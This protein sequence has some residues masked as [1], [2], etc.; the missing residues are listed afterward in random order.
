MT[1]FGVWVCGLRGPGADLRRAPA[2]V[3]EILVADIAA[4]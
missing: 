1:V 2:L 3:V 4:V